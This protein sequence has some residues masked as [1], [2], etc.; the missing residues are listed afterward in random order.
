MICRHCTTNASCYFEMWLHLLHLWN[1][2]DTSTRL[3]LAKFHPAIPRMINDFSPW[4]YSSTQCVYKSKKVH[5]SLNS[6]C[7]SFPENYEPIQLTLHS[8][9]SQPAIQPVCL[10]HAYASN[11]L[12]AICRAIIYRCT[13]PQ[14]TRARPDHN[15]LPRTSWVLSLHQSV[16]AKK[17]GFEKHET[18]QQW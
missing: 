3:Y 10:P 8:Y 18:L 9:A 17:K 5:T 12:D 11:P 14:C 6:L 7:A 4:Y 13:V 15:L 2:V 1:I 16:R